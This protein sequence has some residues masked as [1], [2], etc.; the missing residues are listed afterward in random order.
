M[1]YNYINNE[2]FWAIHPIAHYAIP[3]RLRAPMVCYDG[4]CY[5]SEYYPYML[6]DMWIRNRYNN[7][8]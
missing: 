2:N 5:N 7:W 1:I 3:W 4:Y 8:W 6:K